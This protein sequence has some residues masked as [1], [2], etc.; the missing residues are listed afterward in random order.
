[1]L[2]TISSASRMAA[3]ITAVVALA[4][5]FGQFVAGPAAAQM[6]QA[7]APGLGFSLAPPGAIGTTPQPTTRERAPAEPQQDEAAPQQTP[8]QD[9]P[10]C[11]YRDNKLELLV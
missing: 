9:G 7:P 1:M 11:S 4:L 10:G 2:Q 3:Q 8:S 6:Q 5:A